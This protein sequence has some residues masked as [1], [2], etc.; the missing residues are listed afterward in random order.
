MGGENGAQTDP[1]KC[2]SKH[3][4]A[5]GTAWSELPPQL[6]MESLFFFFNQ[7][8]VNLSVKQTGYQEELTQCKSN[9][10]CFCEH[11]AER[12]NFRLGRSFF[13]DVP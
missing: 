13:S 12:A 9:G 5:K 4:I 8:Q 2:L 6:E 10:H 11:R 1:K 7:D 3:T